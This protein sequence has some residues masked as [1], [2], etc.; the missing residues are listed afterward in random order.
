MKFTGAEVQ[1]I[2][3]DKARALLDYPV[4]KTFTASVLYGEATVIVEDTDIMKEGEN[5]DSND[6]MPEV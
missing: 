2:L 1:D 5:G 3:I 4:S 6:Q